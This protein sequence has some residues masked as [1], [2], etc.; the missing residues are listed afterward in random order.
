LINSARTWRVPGRS[1]RC[2]KGDERAGSIVGLGTFCQAASATEPD[3]IPNN[4]MQSLMSQGRSSSFTGWPRELLAKESQRSDLRAREQWEVLCREEGSV[5]VGRD[6]AEKQ[7]PLDQTRK[8]VFSRERRSKKWL[9]L[10][11][12]IS[13]FS[14]WF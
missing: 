9:V 10:K 8:L 1:R 6:D 5:I 11:S 12:L 2:A 7:L 13:T 4:V 3:G 14:G